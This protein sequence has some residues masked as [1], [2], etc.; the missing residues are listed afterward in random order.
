M[1]FRPQGEIFLRSLTFVRD[2]GPRET[3]TWRALRRCGSHLFSGFVLQTL[4][5]KYNYVWLVFEPLQ[6][7][8]PESDGR[9]DSGQGQG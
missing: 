1:S 9:D 3:I 6:A 7:F 4:S 8:Q 5:D 2:D